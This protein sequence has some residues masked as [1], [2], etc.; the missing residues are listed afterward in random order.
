MESHK[1]CGK[2][3]ILYILEARERYYYTHEGVQEI[4]TAQ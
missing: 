2:Y 1:F 4:R 3:F